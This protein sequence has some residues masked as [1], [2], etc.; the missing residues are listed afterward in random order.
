MNETTNLN[1]INDMFDTHKDKLY[2]LSNINI[3]DDVFSK[4]DQE[5]I[6][7]LC[8][9]DKYYYEVRQNNTDCGPN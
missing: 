4:K 3:V 7:K 2:D 9:N 6:Y 5:E 1:I 8:I